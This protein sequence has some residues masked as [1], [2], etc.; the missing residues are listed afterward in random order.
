MDLDNRLQNVSVIGAGGKMGSGITLLL[1]VEM[2]RLKNLPENKGKVF[3]LNCID[4]N[5]QL[6]DG[7]IGYLRA[8]ATKNAEK[9]TVMLRKLFKDR[10]DLIENTDIINKFVGDVLSVISTSPHL[11]SAADSHMVFEAIVENKDVKIK[12]FDTLKGLC[13]PDTFFFTNTSSIPINIL[14][15]EAGLGG[16]II[17]FHFYN[18]PA[19]QKLA[20]LISADETRP[21]LRELSL[22]IARRLR[23]I[24]VPSHDIAGFIGN[25][26]FIRD[27][28]HAMDEV[29]RLQEEFSYVDSVY[30]MN[31]VS[32]DYLVR[33][34]G[35]FQLI[36]YVGVDVFQCI[37]KVM[38]T[39]IDS[40]TLHSELVDR[41]VEK[42]V[43]GGQ[44]PDGS[45]KD[46][47][48]KYERGRPAGIYDLDKGEYIQIEKNGW[49]GELDKKLGDMPADFA[50]WKALLMNPKK[51]DKLSAY[52]TNLD[53][54]DAMGADLA[55]NYM[56]RS[57]EIG[58]MLV[59]NGVAAEEAH[60]NDVLT[61]GF[62]HLY[63]PI[64]ELISY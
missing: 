63:G 7:L 41:M 16:R 64:N 54:T 27:G 50:P 9:S 61:N 33:P 59:Q 29:K 21:E 51:Q 25:G 62:F 34:M 53:K 3:C 44:N 14:D 57:K 55:R 37:F 35:I 12:I 30:I 24:V 48:L 19:V 6:L 52:F 47:F 38:D 1:A 18:P 49:A 8:Q 22:D 45:Q 40:E 23:K 4:V 56:K 2:A 31:K 58:L 17:G 5:P 20:E 46:G 43:L 11:E 10:A 39:Y 28:L 26:H 15:R 60:V 32:Q 13:S 36:D 42:K